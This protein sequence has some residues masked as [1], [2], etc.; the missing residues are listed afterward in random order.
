M[1]LRRRARRTDV[2]FSERG[3]HRII[4]ATDWRGFAAVHAALAQPML[5]TSI[6]GTGTG[7]YSFMPIQ[8]SGGAMKPISP[9]SFSRGAMRSD[10]AVAPALIAA[11]A[12]AA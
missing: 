9:F 2:G 7:K 11:L 1:R 4:K 10:S 5:R 12:P 8:V 3:S 6:N